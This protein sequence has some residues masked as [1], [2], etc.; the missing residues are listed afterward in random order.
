MKLLVPETGIEPVWPFGR[1][2]LSPKKEVAIVKDILFKSLKII[3]FIVCIYDRLF[4]Y[5]LIFRV[6]R[7]WQETPPKSIDFLSPTQDQ[8]LFSQVTDIDMADVYIGYTIPKKNW[9]NRTF[10][11]ESTRPL[12]NISGGE[13]TLSSESGRKMGEW[14]QEFFRSGML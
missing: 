9:K 14:K 13:R 2:I 7:G 1:G 4:S 10:D 12:S 5:N 11:G 3:E 6:T 8:G